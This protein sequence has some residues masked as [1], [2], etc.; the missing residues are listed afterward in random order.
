ML[1]RQHNDTACCFG[2]GG[3]GR[4]QFSH[5]RTAVDQGI[6]LYCRATGQR[7][8]IAHLGPNRHFQRNRRPDSPRNGHILINH[9]LACYGLSHIH[10]RLDIGYY[11]THI[12]RNAAF[13]HNPACHFMHQYLF[14]TGRVKIR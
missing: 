7:N 14:I 8:E 3:L 12:E 1:H 5:H 9:R 13:R 10:Q 4:S 6:G 11:G 2:H